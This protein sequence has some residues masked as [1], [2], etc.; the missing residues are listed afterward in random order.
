M[1]EGKGGERGK[2]SE[3]ERTKKKGGQNEGVTQI[4]SNEEIRE[5]GRGTTAHRRCTS[6]LHT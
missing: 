6:L 2:E 4:E 5:G 1:G 3:G